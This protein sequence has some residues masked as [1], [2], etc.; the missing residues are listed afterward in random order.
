MNGRLRVNQAESRHYAQLGFPDC[1]DAMPQSN[2]FPKLTFSGQL[3][4]AGTKSASVENSPTMSTQ[5]IMAL[6][7]GGTGVC[8]VIWSA[9]RGYSLGCP[10]ALRGRISNA[11]RARCAPA[12]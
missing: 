7:S 4:A 3:L 11:S 1:A 9:H 6:I 5:H 12:V 2:L 10:L 8:I